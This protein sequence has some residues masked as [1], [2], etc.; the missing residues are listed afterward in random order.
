MANDNN[1]G[2][3]RTIKLLFGVI[4]GAFVIILG[5]LS[6]IYNNIQDQLAAKQNAFLTNR[7]TIYDLKNE[8]ARVNTSED[9]QIKY[10]WKYFEALD[11]RITAIEQ[12]EGRR[13]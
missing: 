8:M 11:N 3:D 5:V 12:F 7:Q 6:I 10:L 9:E 13:K 1:T 2:T 4:S